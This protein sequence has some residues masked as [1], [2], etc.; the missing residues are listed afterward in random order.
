MGISIE[1]NVTGR[2]VTYIREGISSGRWKQGDKIASENELCGVTGASRSSVRSALQRFIALGI[3]ESIHGK[4]TFLRS[5]D[6]TAFGQGLKEIYDQDG[7]SQLMKF[8]LLIEPGIAR[9]AAESATEK[10]IATLKE[11]LYQMT[12]HVDKRDEFLY[13]DKQFH[14]ELCRAMNNN[15][16]FNVM[17]MVFQ[18]NADTLRQLNLAV[19]YYNGIYYHSLMLDAVSNHDGK[20]AYGYMFEHLF[21]NFDDLGIAFNPE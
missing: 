8:R 9:Q 15:L 17:S 16:A 10:N 4:G 11:H 6:M 19:G 7:L 2:V 20:R 18:N 21:N 12:K 14:L 1:E 3:L 13:Y 5:T